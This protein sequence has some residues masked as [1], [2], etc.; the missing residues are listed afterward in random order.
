[1]TLDEKL[2]QAQ[3]HVDRGRIVIERQRA[4]VARDGTQSSIDLL[5]LFERTQ[6]IFELDLAEL[7]EKKMPGLQP[8][9]A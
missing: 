2:A 3:R 7:L 6:Q 1:M 9:A 8:P 4:I 5:E